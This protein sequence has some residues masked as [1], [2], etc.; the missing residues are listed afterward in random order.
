VNRHIK[1]AVVA[2]NLSAIAENAPTSELQLRPLASLS[3]KNQRTVW[4]KAIELSDGQQPAAEQ[5]DLLARNARID[6]WEQTARRRSNR[7]RK[8][9]VSLA[10]MVDAIEVL[11]HPSPNVQDDAS[12]FY[13]GMKVMGVCKDRWKMRWG[14]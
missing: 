2:D 4:A 11:S 12:T 10:E 1:A 3:P 14:I 7:R 5:L 9:G 8:K 13:I 6:R